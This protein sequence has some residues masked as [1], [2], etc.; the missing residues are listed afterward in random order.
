MPALAFTPHLRQ[1]LDCPDG[2]YPG[3]TVV[4]VLNRA[5]AMQ[6]KLRG[7]LLDDQGRLRQ[8]VTIFVN[9]EPLRDR[10]RQTDAVGER[11]E[12][13]VFQALSGG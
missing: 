8:H 1:H 4:A 13:F 5:F 10:A 11:D 2:D 7:Y 6:P 3:N 9:G 12:I